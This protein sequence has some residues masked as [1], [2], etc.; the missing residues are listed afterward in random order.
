MKIQETLKGQ[1]KWLENTGGGAYSTAGCYDDITQEL[2]WPAG[3]DEKKEQYFGAYQTEN[4]NMMVT[5]VQTMTKGT[6]G[7]IMDMRLK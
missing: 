3:I 6:A 7:F 5:D 4:R 1:Q 2:V